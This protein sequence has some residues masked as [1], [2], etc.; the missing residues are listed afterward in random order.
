MAR[1]KLFLLLVLMFTWV[2]AADAQ[3]EKTKS[4]E[5][6]P[7]LFT[8]NGKDVRVSE[9]TYIYTKTNG[10]RA[11]FS[12]QSLEEYLDLYKR[13]KLKV[14]K[15]REMK[16][17]TIPAL[18]SELEGYRRQ[19]ADSYLIDREVTERLVEEAYKHST[20]DL[21]L[22]H[23][24]VTMPG[25]GQDTSRAYYKINEARNMLLKGE[26]F[27]SVAIR[28]S[29][30]KSARVNHGHVGYVT[31]LFPNGLY[32]LEKA[33]YAAP[34]GELVG[35]VRTSA[36][37]HLFIVHDRRPAR[38]EAECAHIMIR[39]PKDAPAGMNPKARIDSIYQVL[40]G[41]ANFEELAKKVSEDKNSANNGGYIGFFGINRFEKSFEDAVFALEK[42][43]DFS[44]PFETSAGWHVVKLVSKRPVGPYNSAKAG[45]MTKVK[46][47]A[48]FEEARIAMIER[49]KKDNDFKEFNTT[50]GNF[51]DTLTKDFLTYKWKAPQ[52]KPQDIIFSFGSKY[53]ASIGDFMEFLEKSA[54][55]R[56][57]L[58][59]AATPQEAAST[60]YGE[61][62][63]EQALKFEEQLLETKYP[64]FKF[65]MREYEE[66]ILLFEATKMVVW[67]KAAQDTVGLENFF[68]TIKGK[69]TWQERA[70]LSVYSINS[71]DKDLLD[72]VQKFAAKNSPEEVLK[73][74]NT[75]G[76]DPL[77]VHGDKTAEKG[78]NKLVENIPWQ[79][80]AL[81]EPEVN[82]RE[83][84]LSFIKIEKILPEADKSLDEARGYVIADYQD[85]LEKQWVEQLKK[86]YPV[87]VNEDVF[88]SMIK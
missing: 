33:A 53:K 59:N 69:Y 15:A 31:A 29:E 79:V 7:V 10:P 81:T 9:F 66:G 20:E 41:G 78:R 5:D 74:F 47:D 77:I 83:K 40:K 35:P 75:E 36:G 61:F 17:D 14:Q 44:A 46:N 24:L 45:L 2:V 34:D 82:E 23:I 71:L 60:L 85:Y 30:D 86:E 11:N 28:Y 27:D 43:G 39:K 49:I 80:G 55:K 56:I 19:L 32:K 62:V 8:V 1:Y 26:P 65:L 63:N 72:K 67:D 52:V 18:K 64:E 73:K 4:K 76:Q 42:N 51:T 16:L 68:Q 21:N 84:T 57:R 48:R 37:Y 87:K 58:A 50:L 88:R 6:D 3:K 38:G 25:S 13:F 54:R 12:R 22:S 70:K